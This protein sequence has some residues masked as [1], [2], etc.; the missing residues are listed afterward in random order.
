M[1]VNPDGLR[2]SEHIGK[3]ETVVGIYENATKEKL[4][5]VARQ[6]GSRAWVC[7]TCKTEGCEHVRLV[8]NWLRERR[9]SRE[10][11]WRKMDAAYP[12][13][14]PVRPRVKFAPCPD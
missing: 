13:A 2:F 10:E 3:R 12:V 5:E 1:C 4:A 6:K 11:L 8:R 7:R 14:E 9:S